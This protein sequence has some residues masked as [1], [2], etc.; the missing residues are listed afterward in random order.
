MVFM[1]L[2]QRLDRETDS[3]YYCF[4]KQQEKRGKDR[5]GESEKRRR[6]ADNYRYHRHIELTAN[7][8][9]RKSTNTAIQDCNY[10]L[11]SSVC[12]SHV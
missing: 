9:Y 12:G 10:I 7:I 5:D 2:V 3:H 1:C 6:E 8:N 4:K 11:K